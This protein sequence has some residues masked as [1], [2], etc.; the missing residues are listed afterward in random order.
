MVHIN[1]MR[2]KS[3]TQQVVATGNDLRDDAIMNAARLEGEK[4]TRIKSLIYQHFF[5]HGM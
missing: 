3:E 2:K 5:L 1:E 4:K